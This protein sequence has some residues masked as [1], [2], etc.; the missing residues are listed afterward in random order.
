MS[1]DGEGTYVL[2]GLFATFGTDDPAESETFLLVEDRDWSNPS[3]PGGADVWPGPRT[4]CAGPNLNSLSHR[5]F[6]PPAG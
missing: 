2:S 1:G 3:T 4:H 5:C 6:E